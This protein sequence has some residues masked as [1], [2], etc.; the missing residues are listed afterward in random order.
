MWGTKERTILIARPGLTVVIQ[1]KMT[2]FSQPHYSN[3]PLFHHSTATFTGK[4]IELE[5][6]LEDPVFLLEINLR[7]IS[8]VSEKLNRKLE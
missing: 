3:T 5:P 2:P 4:D 6:G 8:E 7:V 1:K